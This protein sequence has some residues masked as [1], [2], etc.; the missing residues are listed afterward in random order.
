MSGKHQLDKLGRNILQL[1][2]IN[3]RIPYLEMAR[4]LIVSGGTIHH[5]IDK[6]REAGILVGHRAVIDHKKLGYKVSTLIGVRLVSAHSTEEVIEHLSTMDEVVEAYYT[7]GGFALIIK[8]ITRDI[9]HYHQFLVKKLQT[10]K[11][12]QSTESFIC[13]DNPIS[14]DLKVE[15]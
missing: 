1:L 6:L 5:K 7:T 2:Q 4:R 14:R 10:I 11:E 15:L 13:L 8:V 12:I 3:A 9:D